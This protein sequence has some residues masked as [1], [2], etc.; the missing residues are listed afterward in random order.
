MGISLCGGF[1]LDLRGSLRFTPLAPQ[2]EVEGIG[3]KGLIL[4]YEHREPRR[5]RAGLGSTC[6]PQLS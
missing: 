2:D 6:A 1:N 4:R 5:K 3:L